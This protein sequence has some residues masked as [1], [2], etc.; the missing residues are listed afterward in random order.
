MKFLI[1]KTNFIAGEVGERYLGNAR[2]EDYN[3][4]CALLKNF[5]ILKNGGVIRRPGTRLSIGIVPID[6]KR[7]Y[8][9]IPYKLAEDI[10]S[11][12]QKDIRAGSTIGLVF[13]STKNTVQLPSLSNYNPVFA[14]DGDSADTIS[15]TLGS[16]SFRLEAL[17]MPSNGFDTEGFSATRKRYR[18][19]NIANTFNIGDQRRAFA[20]GQMADDLAKVQVDDI[21][22]VQ[23]GLDMYIS[24][25]DFSGMRVRFISGSLRTRDFLCEI[26]LGVQQKTPMSVPRKRTNIIKDAE[27]Q[28]TLFVS[29]NKD[30]F[31][32]NGYVET[33]GDSLTLES[34]SWEK[35]ALVVGFARRQTSA[36]ATYRLAVITS[37]RYQAS[38][39]NAQ[40]F[41]T[42]PRQLVA[43]P[44]ELGPLVKTIPADPTSPD[45]TTFPVKLLDNNLANTRS[46]YFE[47]EGT[48]KLNDA[49]TRDKRG[50]LF[51]SQNLGMTLPFV[52]DAI[53][54]LT[55]FSN[56]RDFANQ[57]TSD[58]FPL[59][60]YTL[61]SMFVYHAT[62]SG[63]ITSS[64]GGYPDFDLEAYF[65]R[66]GEIANQGIQVLENMRTWVDLLITKG[67]ERPEDVNNFV[68]GPDV[69]EV[70]LGNYA[71][72]P[73]LYA[74]KGSSNKILS[75]PRM[76][77]ITAPFW[78]VDEWSNGN[79]PSVVGTY[80][81]RLV[82]GNAKNAPD[83]LWFSGLGLAKLDQFVDRHFPQDETGDTTGVDYPGEVNIDDPFSLRVY[84]SVLDEIRWLN[85]EENLVIGMSGSAK[86][87]QGFDDGQLG[88]GSTKVATV[89]NYSSSRSKAVR[90]GDTI[91]FISADGKK[92]RSIGYSIQGQMLRARDVT[93]R[94]D[95]LIKDDEFKQIVFC[96]SRN[97][98]FLLTKQGKLF[99]YT[100]LEESPIGAWARHELG[101]G[102]LETQIQSMAIVPNAQDGWDDV[103]FTVRRA[104]AI[105]FEVLGRDYIN[106]ELNVSPEKDFKYLEEEEGRAGV[107]YYMD[108]SVLFLYIKEI[109]D[110]PITDDD[111]YKGE[112]SIID[113]GGQN[114]NRTFIANF[115]PITG[116]LQALFNGSQIKD[117]KFVKV[118]GANDQVDIVPEL[119]SRVSEDI[120][121]L[122]QLVVGYAYKSE[123]ETTPVSLVVREGTAQASPARM[124]TVTFRVN[125]AMSAR[126][127]V[128]TRSTEGDV[129]EQALELE[130]YNLKQLN[131]GVVR[132]YSG[133]ERLRVEADQG[134]DQRVF[135]EVEGA[136]PFTL[137]SITM[138]G[139]VND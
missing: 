44:L 120:V 93:I 20:V 76:F 17:L 108:S 46:I 60:P 85:D 74:A 24:H 84:S 71:V 137:L 119:R 100:I 94:N 59:N 36:E 115:L 21:D 89:S 28:G 139:V 135:V 97:M 4:G 69:S 102:G 10:G 125:Q 77:C 128:R 130:N 37:G 127:G 114:L 32:Y 54:P 5:F 35:P 40:I 39:N 138:R 45:R 29:T 51:R 41:K 8:R 81:Q 86:S 3:S 68:R 33:R 129:S 105:V 25:K 56:S 49:S 73:D 52:S 113:N 101:T 55:V 64:L 38:T 23:V 90:A 134:E 98:L 136:Y 57:L 121:Q 19:A 1:D 53:F 83:S 132:A 110:P 43:V 7:D 16:E 48:T 66:G 112:Y 80:Q 92:L 12:N 2:Q 6:P 104:G 96:E 27:P 75:N 62:I 61:L 15:E 31:N 42:F 72:G 91:Y 9:I 118:V 95:I 126:V 26:E 18:F 79:Y 117:L 123:M 50:F 78:F 67:T 109:R 107:P 133:L 47:L 65:L 111:I 131:D 106:E 88:A 99:T 14:G 30:L 122:N 103:W 34:S 87:V 58:F 11:F 13:S 63:S 70:Q 124:D 22:W 82:Y 116:K